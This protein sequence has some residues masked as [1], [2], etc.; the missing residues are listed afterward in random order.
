MN[1][2]ENAPNP[3]REKAIEVEEDY[4]HLLIKLFSEE[5]LLPYKRHTCSETISFN[6]AITEST[7]HN[8]VTTYRN[9]RT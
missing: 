6:R 4:I 8:F 9:Y 3:D 7:I 2:N 5:Y 1:Q